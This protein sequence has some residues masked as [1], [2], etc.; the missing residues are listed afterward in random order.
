[1]DLWA[2]LLR[3]VFNVTSLN[4][5][6]VGRWLGHMP[7]T[8]RHANIGKSAKKPAE[9]FIG[10]SAHYLIGIVFALTLVLATAGD[11]LK[12]PSLSAALIWGIGTVFIPL[13]IM[14][15]CL[16]LGV[17]AAKTPNPA[18]ARIKSLITHAVFG[19]GLYLS[20]MPVSYLMFS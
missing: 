12:Q 6:L 19:L 20:A 13:F 14:Q 4:F 18:Q 17:A 1:M 10:W 3:R 16:G 8:F 5:C 11:W 2:L 15:P 9:C 7:G